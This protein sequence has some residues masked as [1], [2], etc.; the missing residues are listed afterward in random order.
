MKMNQKL[1][2][3]LIYPALLS[4]CLLA[5]CLVGPKYHPPAPQVPAAPNYKESPVNFKDQEGWKVA[6]PSDAKIKG[7]WW[8]MYNQPEL[9]TLED[10]LN[11]NNQNIQVY[12]QNFMA[13]RAIIA[14]ARSQYYPTVGTNPSWTRSRGSATLSNSTSSNTGGGTVTKAGS[15]G[16]VW[17]LPLDVSWTPDFFGKIRNQ[18]RSAQ[19]AAQVSAADLENEKLT[20]EAALAQAYFE[21]RGQ[22][23]LIQ[24]LTETVKAD[25]ESL[26]LTQN[27]YD[28]GID[29]YI[30]VVEAQATLSAA[31]AQLTNLGILRA[32]YEHAIAVLLGRTATD[33]SVPTKPMLV[34]PPAIPVGV[35]SQLLERR[36]DVA[37]AERTL[38]E[39]NATI[40]IGY[41][42]F[43]PT[44]TLSAT[45]GFQSATA[46]NL[47]TWPSRFWSIGPQ[48]AQ[49][50]FNGWLYRAEL[51]QYVAEYN[52]NLASYRETTLVAFQQVEDGLSAVRI[53]SQQIT[54]LQAAVKA[55]QQYLD[56][57]MQRYQTGIDPYV[58]VLIAQNTLLAD[59][60]AL[61]TTQISQ[62]TSSVNLV[63]AL[64]GGWDNSQLPS[65]QDVSHTSKADYKLP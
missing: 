10:Q 8:E 27:L 35:P 45:G 62:M 39:D 24:I 30:S 2:R 41:G 52:A 13:A 58:D 57:E 14:E 46:G 29:A 12:F 38:A 1:S 20:E 55:A 40:G 9:N 32:Q 60:Q 56:L 31:Q 51:H 15:T 7:N 42:A 17:N 34:A 26:E 43:F 64:G 18:V 65:P 23:A 28:T 47:L 49:T 6:S 11:I 50:L 61:A 36:P 54:E 21:I 22:D 48:F 37:A 63:I 33:F 25:Q 4:L 16:S 53:Y 59:Q 44:V 3:I 5:G 19:Y